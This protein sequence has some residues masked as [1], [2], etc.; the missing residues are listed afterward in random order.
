MTTRADIVNAARSLK[1]MKWQH[2]GRNEH[3][4]DCVG[5]VAMVAQI[6]GA[7]PDIEFESNYRRR[8]DGRNMVRLFTEYCDPV[9]WPDAQPGDFFVVRYSARHWHCMIVSRREENLETEFYVIEAGREGVTIDHR[10]DGSTK[11]RIHSAYRVRN[12]EG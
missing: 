2:Q 10:I 5:F 9:E 6:S 7:V 1:G 12:L 11:R 3:G 8:S 4:S